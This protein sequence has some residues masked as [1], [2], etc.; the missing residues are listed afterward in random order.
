MRED[1]E[2]HLKSYLRAGSVKSWSD[3]Q[4]V[5]GLKWF[6]DI[7]SALGGDRLQVSTNSAS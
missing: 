6:G 1:L 2:R 4:I 5:P 7:K 3:E